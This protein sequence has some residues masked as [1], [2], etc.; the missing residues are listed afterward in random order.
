MAIR[1][2]TTRDERRGQAYRSGTMDPEVYVLSLELHRHM[3]G[4]ATAAP[5]SQKSDRAHFGTFL[6]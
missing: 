1:S 6:P 3:K 4:K 5:P 2:L